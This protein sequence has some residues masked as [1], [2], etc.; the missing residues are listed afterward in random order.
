MNG[1]Q[2]LPPEPRNITMNDVADCAG[3][4]IKSV[5]RVINNEPHVSVRLRA[6]VEQAIA[7]LGWVPD[8]A[9]RSLAGARSFVIGVMFDN[10]SPNYTMKVVAGVYAACIENQ[11]HLRFDNIA[12]ASED[13]AAITRRLDE[14]FR[15]GRCDGF[16]LTP[17]LCDHTVVL[18]Y[19][20]A[21]GIR[22]SRIAPAHDRDRA[23]AAVMDDFGA[24]GDVAALFHRHGHRRIGVINGPEHHSAALL[25]REGFVTRMAALNPEAIVTDVRGDFTF[26]SGIAA[27]LDLLSA[28]R[29]P[30]AIFATNDDMAAGVIAACNQMGLSVPGDVSVCG[31]DD[32]WVASAVFPYLTTVHQPIEGMAH[33]AAM[34]LID[35][36]PP[37]TPV[38][39][40]LDHR[41]IERD[42]VR[43]LA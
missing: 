34:M 43:G 4:S 14:V 42:S 19:L 36:K 5:S 21:R 16:V 27:G 7:Q 32:S 29:H 8:T 12:T 6:R 3:V 9:A 10:P 33:A 13:A 38:L 37:A 23:P 26:Q 40:Q 2:A 24:G 28:R 18:D 1:E 41:L 35:R 11:Y 17:P 25:R 39:R 30:S 22:Y 20:D 15:L 31:F